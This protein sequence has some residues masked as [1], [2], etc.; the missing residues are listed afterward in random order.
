MNVQ[1]RTHTF[2]PL[3]STKKDI[4]SDHSPICSRVCPKKLRKA[5]NA[6]IPKWIAEYRVFHQKL[7]V[8][9]ENYNGELASF[10][11]EAAKDL[12][13]LFREASRTTI[14]E[15]Y[16]TLATTTPEKFKVILQAVRCIHLNDFRL[17]RYVK[18]DLPEIAQHLDLSGD[19]IQL[20]NPTELHKQT[21]RNRAATLQQFPRRTQFFQERQNKSRSCRPTPP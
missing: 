13:L 9:L 8:L 4:D 2:T 6:P 14:K 1:I 19:T 21:N 10:P 12:K 3:A 20:I 5:N 18:K 7:S 11:Y 16:K 15:T 17:A